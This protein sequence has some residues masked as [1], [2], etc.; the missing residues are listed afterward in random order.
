MM[1]ILNDEENRHADRYVLSRYLYINVTVYCF[2]SMLVLANLL[3]LRFLCGC[4]LEG[5]KHKLLHKV[6]QG[7]G[8]KNIR[9][10]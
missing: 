4:A 6:T 3:H 8:E 9:E 1:S 2:S 5:R 10:S 7:D